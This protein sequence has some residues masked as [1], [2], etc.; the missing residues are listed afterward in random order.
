MKLTQRSFRLIH[1][2]AFLA[3]LLLAFAPSINQLRQNSTSNW[4][5]LCTNDGLRWIQI[6]ADFADV[7]LPAKQ[8]KHFDCDYC[9]LQAGTPEALSLLLIPVANNIAD[10]FILHVYDTPYLNNTHSSQ[11]GSRGPPQV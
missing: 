5:E 2:L 9:P 6:K 4:T 7:T 3:A 8:Q 11:L 10:S 1:S